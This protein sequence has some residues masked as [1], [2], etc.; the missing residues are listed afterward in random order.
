MMRTLLKSKIHGATVTG[1]FLE[2]EGSI[3]ID[4]RVLRAADI[5]PF[6]L[7]HVLNLNNGARI[8]TYAIAGRAGSG[9]VELNGPAARLGE[10]SDRV[11]VLAY[12]IY[13]DGT[14]AR[15]RI[16]RLGVGN[17]VGRA[18]TKAGANGASAA[19]ARG[20]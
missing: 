19:R 18:R 15:P 12:G 11:I 14:R 6:E 5:E 13:P 10:L 17:R 8:E 3:K 20:R 4:E 1:K 16:V 9:V 7:V 2:Y